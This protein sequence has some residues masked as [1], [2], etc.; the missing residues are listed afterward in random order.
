YTTL[1]NDENVKKTVEG[2]KFTVPR[3]M[4][5]C[6]NVH[7]E[8][9]A[10]PVTPYLC[11]IQQVFKKPALKKLADFYSERIPLMQRIYLD[12]LCNAILTPDL[13]C[14]NYLKDDVW[15][16]IVNSELP[17][18]K[19]SYKCQ[20]MFNKKDK[21]T[22]Q[23]LKN[24][25]SKLTSDNT[26]CETR[27]NKDF[28]SNFPLQN[29]STLSQELNKAKLV[30][31]YHDCPGNVD[32]EALTNIHRIV[33]HFAPRKIITSKET[34]A[35][36]ANYTL[37]RL[38]LDIK[39]DAGW[40]LK[41]CYL[42]RVQGKE[43][44][45][46]YIPGSRTDEPLSEDQVVAKIIYQQKGAPMR[47]TCRI[48]D[49]KTYNP[50]RSEFKFGCF[51]VYDPNACT[52]LQCEKK[53]I[54]EEKAQADIKFVGVPMFDYFPSNYT[55]ERFSFTSL[56]NEVKSTQEKIIRNLTDA[57]GFLNSAP[58]AII[59]GIGC[60]EDLMPE[61]F[62]RVAINQCHPMPFIIDGFLDKDGETR[63]VTR[64]SIDDIHTPRFLMWPNF[65]N[66]VSA[67]REL[68]PLNTW[69]LYGLKK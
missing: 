44:C 30:T 59:H 16:K 61:L 69:T 52:T 25:A 47:T 56:I 11:R 35:G 57:K 68:H 38:N 53:V 10:N 51:I 15:N 49:T 18:Y 27:G 28:L 34:C 62:Q 29:C 65:Y 60:S 6:T 4:A 42:D 13:F 32:N 2:I 1:F 8:W 64:L 54:W 55:T 58:D 40:P 41:I 63:L 31:N 39:N 37:A 20:Q 14:A 46:P 66:A 3:N 19:M 22:V 48:V 7:R 33:N 24:C 43:A 45:T 5:E 17:D 23:D 12:N 50:L 67:Y 26:F 9:L 36:E 21:L